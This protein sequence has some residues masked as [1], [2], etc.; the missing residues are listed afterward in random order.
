MRGQRS[1]HPTA[2]A[3]RAIA[4]SMVR[5]GY[6]LNPNISPD[7]GGAFRYIRLVARTITPASRADR[8]MA[9]S[10]MPFLV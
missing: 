2:F 4:V 5:R 3:S 1:S 10:K 8:S 7:R 9:V 6:P